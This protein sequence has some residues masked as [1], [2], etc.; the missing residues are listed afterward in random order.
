MGRPADHTGIR[1]EM[2]RIEGGK[3]DH[4][5]LDPAELGKTLYH[6]LFDGQL[7]RLPGLFAIDGIPCTAIICAV[8]IG[9][10]KKQ[11]PV[12]VCE[13]LRV[14]ATAA[15]VD[16]RDELGIPRQHS[17]DFQRLE[18]E[19]ASASGKVPGLSATKPP[20]TY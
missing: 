17:A 8:P 4:R 2:A 14:R 15:R 19:S 13:I 20:I 11:G 16:V 6:R 10:L 5:N 1:R 12:H 3:R 18:Q 7:N 9:R